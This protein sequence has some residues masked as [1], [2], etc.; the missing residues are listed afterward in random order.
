MNFDF[1]RNL[2]KKFTKFLREYSLQE[3]H[4]SEVIGGGL[5]VSFNIFQ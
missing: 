1:W 5:Q 4:F 2:L 3:K